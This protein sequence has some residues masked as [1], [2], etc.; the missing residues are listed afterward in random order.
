[1]LHW[2][3]L[4]NFTIVSA[5]IVL[6]VLGIFLATIIRTIDP[7]LRTFFI[8]Y[9]SVMT[10]Y[11]TNDM[12]SQIALTNPGNSAFT[13]VSKASIFFES[14]FSSILMPMFTILLLYMAKEHLRCI[15]F[16]LQL[17]LWVSY[18]ILLIITQFTTIIYY[19]SDDNIYHRGAYYPLLLIPPVCMMLTN[20]YALFT[21]KQKLPDSL[22]KVFLIYLIVPMIAMVIQMFFYGILTIVLA[23][24]T[25]ALFMLAY[26]L[27]AQLDSYIE[28]KNINYQQQ[29]DIMVL[30]M[31]PHFIY[32]TMSSI[33]YLIDINP[34]KAKQVIEDFS[35]YL[36]RNFSAVAK[37]GLI[38]FKEELEHTKAYLAVEKARYENLLFIEYDTPH[39]M[40]HLPPLTLQPIVENAVKHGLDPELPKLYVTIR[41]RKTVTRSE[42][43]VENIGA[44]FP[45]NDKDPSHLHIGIAN[46]RKRLALMCHGTLTIEPR[47]NDGGGTIVRIEIPEPISS[48]N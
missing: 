5:G 33:Y 37:N 36:R 2:F 43:I 40:F 3:D 16:Y 32:N 35:M 22:Y 26:I 28:Q 14:L 4:A 48:S 29:M 42:L 11:T 34:T 1:M 18:F 44:D 12:I 24:T 46:V 38:P 15:T 17:A 47:Q 9:F 25:T 10:A 7:K 30:Q 8:A 13:V 19:I 45:E 31:R 41:T 39:T 23:T 21:R 27:N 6:S 20:L